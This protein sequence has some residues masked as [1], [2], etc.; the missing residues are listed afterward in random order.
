MHCYILINSHFTGALLVSCLYYVVYSLY[1]FIRNGGIDDDD[2]N[3]FNNITD[4][5]LLE[6]TDKDILDHDYD[7]DQPSTSYN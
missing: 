1:K 7:H 5:E 4:I 6:R 3:E 2:D